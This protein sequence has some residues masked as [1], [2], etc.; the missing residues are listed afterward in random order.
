VALSFL[1]HVSEPLRI[2]H[3]FRKNEEYPRQRSWSAQKSDDHACEL[4]DQGLMVCNLS[5]ACTHQLQ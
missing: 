3:Q 2:S 1:H 5:I 4:D